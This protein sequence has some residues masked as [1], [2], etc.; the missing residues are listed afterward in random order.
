[1]LLIASVFLF[2]SVAARAQNN[3]VGQ[4][5]D[6][7][8]SG[9]VDSTY[10]V[11]L[12]VCLSG[13]ETGLTAYTEV[14]SYDNT[15][16]PGTGASELL[17]NGNTLIYNSGE[18]D[19]S[20]SSSVS[21]TFIPDINTG[22]SLYGWSNECY[23]SS[24]SGNYSSCQWGYSSSSLGVYGEVTRSVVL[25]TSSPIAASGASLTFTAT[26]NAGITGMITFYDGTS[27]IGTS[28]VS[29][30]TATFT[31]NALAAG[32]HT[33]TAYWPGNVSYSALTSNAIVETIYQPGPVQLPAAGIISTVAGNGI[34]SYAGDGGYAMAA[35]MN[36][37]YGVAV[38]SSGNLYIADCSDHRI[39]KVTV[40]TG[41][42][43]TIAGNGVAG[44]TGDGGA[45]TSARLGCPYGIAVDTSGNVYFSDMTYNRVRKVTATGI[46]S[47]AAGNGNIGYSGDGGPATNA[48]LDEPTGLTVDA[49]GNLYIAD[50]YGQRVRKVTVSTGIIST[51]AGNGYFGYLGD[52]GS[53]TNAELADPEGVAV[54]AAGNIYIADYYNSCIREVAV[55]NKL[56]S[57]VACY[58][59]ALTDII[60]SYPN[61]VVVD[62]A[63]NLYILYTVYDF[64]LGTNYSV[65][66]E[67]VASA[68]VITTLAGNGT[69]GYSGDGGP[70]T[71]AELNMPLGLAIDSS[72]DIYISDTGNERIR[73]VGSSS[74]SVPTLTLVTSS[75]PSV[76]GASVTFTATISSGPT[77]TVTFYDGGTQ[78][79]TGTIG[80]TTATFTTSSLAAGAH[81]ITASWPGNSSYSSV[82]SSTI[83]QVVTSLPVPTL[84][85]A[86]SSTPSNRGTAVTFT[87]TISNGLTG[88]ITF[89]NNGTAIGTGAVSGS[90]ATFTTSSLASGAYSITASWPGNSSYGS[91]TSSAITQTVNPVWDSGTVT[92]NIYNSSNSILFA[93]SASYGQGST[94]SSVAE[95]LAGSNSSIN[96]TAVNDT[97]YIEAGGTGGANT[98]YYYT[99]TTQSIPGISPASFQGSPASGNLAGGANASGT[100]QTIYSYSITNPSGGSGYDPTGNILNYTDSVMGTWSY[101][102]DALNR[103]TSG[104][105][106]ATTGTSTQYAGQSLCWAYDS[107]GN[108]TVQSQQSGACP[109]SSS[110][111]PTWVYN[112][113][114]QVSGVIAP[115]ATQ[116]SPSPYTYDAA[117][118]VTTDVTAGN[119]YLYDAEGR[120]C[121][122]QSPSG[123]GGTIMTGYLYDAEGNRVAKGSITNWSCDPLANGIATAGN[124][125]DYVLGPGGEQVTEL[126]QD[127]NGSM[128]WQRTYVYAGG[129][130]IGTYAPAPN[131]LYPANPTTQ[132]P[133]LP[134]VSFRLTDWLGTLRATTDASG[135]A[136]GTCT[137]LPFG[138]GV[139]CSGD[140]PDPHHFTGKERDTESGNDYFGARYFGSNMGR[141]ISPDPFIPFNLKKDK[142]QAWIANPQHWNK[143]AYAL[144]NPLKYIDPTGMTETVYYFLS[145]NLT[146]AQRDFINKHLGEIESAIADKMHKAGIKDVVFKD[147]SQLS[148]SQVNKILADQP[149]GVNT[150]NFVNTSF[151][152]SSTDVNGG[153]NGAITVVYMGNIAKGGEVSTDLVQALANVGAHELGHGM[154]FYSC[155]LCHW[156]PFSHDLMDENQG[157]F[158][159]TT[160]KD[161]DMSI[162]QNRQAVEE[163][164]AQPEYQPK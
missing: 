16:I 71:N 68:G 125:T 88:T 41:L 96:V 108:R 123:T 19:N 142:F 98:D 149:K 154:G 132:P 147:G 59:D 56:I 2:L 3:S 66:Q 42:I 115:G 5:V 105:N 99:V 73:V 35:E 107:F 20:G 28:T 58:S 6:V 39:R 4:D 74:R 143:Y 146:D 78:I 82:T 140:I 40:S 163:I 114:N 160:P 15:D 10:D 67:V 130:L 161:Y 52:G 124:E 164:N 80:G 63:D 57:T 159:I 116:A 38:D 117:G 60:Y 55:S 33:I 46:I 155:N 23:D 92:L 151:R 106:T 121:A 24:A 87:A 76:Y 44:S 118:D 109:A 144:N 43:S 158:G 93:Q 11:E 26:I 12:T 49:A 100:Q 162:P 110:S 72:D 152:G 65:V 50:T 64:S 61:G 36:N 112:A 119:Q 13:D 48:R 25:S 79:G 127:A 131:P 156:N 37:P 104:Q 90:T 77:G 101:S 81:S 113:N 120:I 34:A 89:Y 157:N 141:F 86:T 135:V 136:Q 126:A 122:S 102:Y 153:H 29:G 32:Y 8:S 17:Y 128:N 51:V 84:T 148:L 1:M 7:C 85:V 138:D 18:V 62:S 111:T 139:T 134:Q 75:T 150:L 31:T 54:D 21:Y 94:P 9:E 145:K 129:A 137:G 22:Y 97:L 103:L 14:D 30:S 53:A 133:T 47:A 27:V 70:A 83:T 91:V 45:A 69:Q 95:A